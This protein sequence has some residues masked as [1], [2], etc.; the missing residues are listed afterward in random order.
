MFEIFNQ[1]K[2]E[3]KIISFVKIRQFYRSCINIEELDIC[4]FVS[5]VCKTL[6]PALWK[7]YYIDRRL[8]F[9]V[10]E[11]FFSMSTLA[12]FTIII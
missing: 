6:F 3:F 10:K 2:L 11:N 7:N 8:H 5:G 12:F 1:F 9:L 4:F